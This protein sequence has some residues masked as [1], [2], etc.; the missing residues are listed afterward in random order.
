MHFVAITGLIGGI[1]AIAA[2]VVV[3]VWPKILAYIIGIYF[4]IL[5]ILA[6]I[7]ALH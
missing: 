6:I 7:A 5:G 1:L 3:I 4:I 2:G